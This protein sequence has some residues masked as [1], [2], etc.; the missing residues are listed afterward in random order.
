MIN[1]ETVAVLGAS[2]NPKRQLVPRRMIRAARRQFA[3]DDMRDILA[4]RQGLEFA[5]RFGVAPL[6][7]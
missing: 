1:K 7:S 3:R 5:S 4:S 6:F 2:N